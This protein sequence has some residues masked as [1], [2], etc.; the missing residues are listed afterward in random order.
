MTAPGSRPANIAETH[1]SGQAAFPAF[2]APSAWPVRHTL[3]RPSLFQ[4]RGWKKF[5]WL[6]LLVFV[7]QLGI[8][9]VT[10]YYYFVYGDPGALLVAVPSAVALPFFFLFMKRRPASYIELSPS[11]LSWVTGRETKAF[12]FDAYT[13]QFI[14]GEAGSGASSETFRNIRIWPKDTSLAPATWRVQT[15]PCRDALT[16]EGFEDLKRDVERAQKAGRAPAPTE[17]R[18]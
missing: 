17:D 9:G 4:R 18:F 16:A 14:Q 11:G 3:L 1:A 13:V 15:I 8:I 6:A 2:A 12:P 7:G 5:R 10:L